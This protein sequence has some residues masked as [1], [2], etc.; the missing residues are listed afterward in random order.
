MYFLANIEK[1]SQY[2]VI[3]VGYNTKMYIGSCIYHTNLN[4]VMV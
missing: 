3:S 4:T 2:I 1:K